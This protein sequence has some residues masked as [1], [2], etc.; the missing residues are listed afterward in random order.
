MRRIVLI[1]SAVAWGCSLVAC[2]VDQPESDPT[3][4]YY[5]D[6]VP[7]LQTSCTRCHYEDG[8]GTGDFNDQELV[9][10]LAEYMLE[11][12]DAG[13]MPPPAGDPSCENYV[14]SDRLTLS[15]EHRDL[16][17]TWIEEGKPLGRP[18]EIAA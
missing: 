4:T 18:E 13:E 6:V 3:Y 1:L 12:V 14:D 9:L 15:P 11:R 5:A 2:A 16:L 10:Q 7:L 17:A 8:N